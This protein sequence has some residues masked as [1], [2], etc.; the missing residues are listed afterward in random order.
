MFERLV[1]AWM[2]A[3]RLFEADYIENPSASENDAVKPGAGASDGHPD[4]AEWIRM[5]ELDD[6]QFVILSESDFAELDDFAC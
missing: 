3:F 2:A 6:R 5:T 1:A 4:P